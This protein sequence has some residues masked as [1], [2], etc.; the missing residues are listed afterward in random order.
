MQNKKLE[1]EYHP[2]LKKILDKKKRELIV[3]LF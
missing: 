2:R 1:L 3:P